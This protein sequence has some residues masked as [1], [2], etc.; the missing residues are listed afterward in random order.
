MSPVVDGQQLI[1]RD[2]GVTL[3]RA[4]RSMAKHLLDGAQICTFVQQVRCKRMPQRMG[5]YR[6]AW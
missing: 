6:T 5:A 3:R 1:H 4:Q 2:M